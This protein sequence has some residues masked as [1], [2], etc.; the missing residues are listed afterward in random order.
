MALNYECTFEQFQL[1]KEVKMKLHF[2]SQKFLI[3]CRVYNVNS[4][5]KYLYFHLYTQ[6]LHICMD[7]VSQ[8]LM[9][10]AWFGS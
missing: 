2:V 3:N 9:K 7:K 10:F 5:W 1:Q 8:Y 6:M 4:V